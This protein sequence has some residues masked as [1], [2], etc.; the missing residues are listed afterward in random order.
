[1]QTATRRRT[2]S[3][4][5]TARQNYDL[6]IIGGGISGA[7]LL[8]DAALRGLKAILLEKNDFASGT[9][10]A[11]SRLI[12]G[13]LRYLK[14]GRLGL[15]RESLRERRILARIAAHA[16]RPARFLVPVG[17]GPTW[18]LRLGLT[19]YDFLSLDRNRHVPES[20]HIQAHQRL[21]AERLPGSW[22][23]IFSYHDYANTNPEWLTVEMI[24]DAE[25]HGAVAHNYTPVEALERKDEAYSVQ[26]RGE[27]GERATIQASMVINAA[28]PWA[29]LIEGKLAKKPT[30]QLTRSRGIHIVTR[31]VGPGDAYLALLQK[32]GKHFFVLPWRGCSIIGTTDTA[33]R[34]DPDRFAVL[35]EDIAEVLQTVN[36]LW[37]DSR[38]ARTDVLYYYGG[39]R[40]LLAGEESSVSTYES[41]RK[42]EVIDLATQGFPH[43]YTVVGGKYTTSR[44]LAE[45]A[46]DLALQKSKKKARDCRTA[47][48]LLPGALAFREEWLSGIK[49]R[50]TALIL[51]GRYGSLAREILLTAGPDEIYTGRNGESYT[52]KEFL[53]HVRHTHGKTLS[54]LYLRRTGMGTTGLP[55]ATTNRAIA[56]LVGQEL[57]WSREEQNRQIRELEQHYKLCR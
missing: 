19:L 43:F 56:R 42:S 26:Y 29:D 2:R 40:P 14:Q 46:I 23:A 21:K 22:K 32:N 8:R 35:E 51:Y 44:H 27:D 45:K 34:G 48:T 6:C 25:R 39:M 17:E 30:A 50:S 9:T 28:G 57:G 10:Q 53:F 31:P 20:N 12:H 15:V 3:A 11:T 49:D 18:P 54:D 24:L 55:D 5:T 1:M 38:L 47:E 13:G 33:Y 4:R 36:E 41:S 52:A 7:C 37:P 16:L